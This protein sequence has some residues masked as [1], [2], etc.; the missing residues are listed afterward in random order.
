MSDI[1][2]FRQLLRPLSLLQKKNRP[3]IERRSLFCVPYKFSSA[4]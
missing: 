1:A 3:K 4:G 2:W